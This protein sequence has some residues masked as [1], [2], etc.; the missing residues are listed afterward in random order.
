[1]SMRWELYLAFAEEV[2]GSQ[3]PAKLQEAAARSAVSRAYYAVFH[4]ARPRLEREGVV[5]PTDGSAHGEVMRAYEQRGDRE[6]RQIANILRELR[7]DRRD[8]DYDDH[9][10]LSPNAATILDRAKQCMLLL[11]RLPESP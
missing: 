10:T 6:R 3:W 4:C 5:L 11:A 2:L 7:N 9:A 8:A 1:V